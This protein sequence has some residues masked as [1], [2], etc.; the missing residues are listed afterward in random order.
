MNKRL[1][2]LVAV[3]LFPTLMWGHTF[4]DLILE[5]LYNNLLLKTLSLENE[6][7][8]YDA[9]ADNTLGGPEVEFS[10]FYERDYSGVASTEL[11]VSQSF[12]FPTLYAARSRANK[13]TRQVL[14]Y[15]LLAAR[16]EIILKAH[17]LAFEQV[18]LNK[19]KHLA[20]RHLHDVDSSLYVYS[21][22][23][24]AGDGNLL[25]LTG[26]KMDRMTAVARIV[27][28][29][30]QMQTAQRE[31]QKLNGGMPFELT[32][33]VYPAMPMPLSFDSLE[34]VARGTS[35]SVL[36]SDYAYAL[37]QQQHKVAR[38]GWLPQ[39]KLGYRRE[40]AF[41]AITVHGILFSVGFPV[42]SNSSRT[43][44][45]RQ[46]LR[47]ASWQQIES[48]IQLTES[49]QAK[50]DEVRLLQRTLDAFDITTLN[51]MLD[52]LGKAV[53]QGHISTLE[54][55]TEAKDVYEKAE[56]YYEAEYR[57]HCLLAE[58]KYF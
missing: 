49:L 27:D 2:L 41:D 1:P 36:G 14:N 56:E 7:T 21:R 31:L 15:Q 38:Q 24:E 42:Y 37:A 57:Y 18:K 26:I 20:D 46:R 10:P 17:L 6:A 48:R 25:D 54:Y 3:F 23:I 34:H 55:Y 45:T 52:L 39:L 8:L 50:W 47:S 12:D 29:E 13:L 32:D 19:M 28:I 5:I 40:T 43:R 44:A 4:D 33:T 35:A 30:A 58:M 22:R 51:Q 16:R 11:I 9:K 53:R